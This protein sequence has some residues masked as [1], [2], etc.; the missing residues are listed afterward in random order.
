MSQTENAAR[1]A[2]WNDTIDACPYK[3]LTGRHIGIHRPHAACC[4]WVARVLTGRNLYRQKCLGPALELG[5]GRIPFEEAV[6]RAIAWFDSPPIRAIAREPRGTGR[7]SGLTF[8]PIGSTYTVGHALADFVAWAR[9]ARSPGGH[10]NNL[11][12]INRHLVG[13]LVHLPLEAFRGYHLKALAEEVIRK[14]PRFGYG[15]E[16]PPADRADLSADQLRRRKRRFN[17]LVSLLRMAF[18]LAWENAHVTSERVWRCAKRVPVQ[19][20][21]R[22]IFLTRDECRSLLAHC[23]PSLRLLVLGALY[24]GCRVGELARLRIED[25]GRQ[26]FGVYVRPFK[27]GP[28]R[29]VFVPDEGMAFLLRC[30]VG[31]GSRDLVFAS[32]MDKPWLRQH[33]RLFRRAVLGAGLPPSFVFHGLRHTYASELIRQGVP[34]DVVARQLGHADTRTVVG[35]YGH[36]AERFREEVIRSRFS[37]LSSEAAEE[38]TRRRAELDAIWQATKVDDWRDY[39]RIEPQDQRP[40]RSYG[41]PDAGVLEAFGE[42]SA[43]E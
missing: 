24:T 10:Y 21:P 23:T 39:A 37:S 31:K 35:T 13:P 9:V 18:L 42:S 43:T 34:V 4:N 28:A 7:M 17:A 33:S 29:F 32:D 15:K 12:L 3:T 41:R 38:A 5:R 14:E 26:V 36:F 8:C 30:C 2:G 19:H 40:Q 6:R 20:A 27:R 11:A 1:C 22:T 16:K 25:V